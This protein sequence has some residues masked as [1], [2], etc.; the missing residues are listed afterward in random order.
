MQSALAAARFRQLISKSLLRPTR[1]SSGKSVIDYQFA[2][3]RHNRPMSAL[4]MVCKILCVAGPIGLSHRQP[5]DPAG[6]LESRGSH[7]CLLQ[8][9]V[10]IQ[11]SGGSQEATS[12]A[13]WHPRLRPMQIYDEATTG[14]T[15]SEETGIQLKDNTSTLSAVLLSA[16]S[17]LAY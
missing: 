10:W 13:G 14:I 1:I 16:V 4:L 5:D 3:N 8:R 12:S 7:L 11:V 6:E 9:K 15:T 2:V 17:Q